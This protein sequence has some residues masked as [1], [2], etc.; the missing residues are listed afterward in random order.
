MIV[1]GVMILKRMEKRSLVMGNAMSPGP[2]LS[3][4]VV[5]M[6]SFGW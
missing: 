3:D 5:V 1:R 2:S 4:V 6:A